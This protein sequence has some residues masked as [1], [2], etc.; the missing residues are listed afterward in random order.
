MIKRAPEAVTRFLQ[1]VQAIGIL[2]LAQVAATK[3]IPAFKLYHC[4]PCC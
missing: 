4:I 1:L 2:F 3:V